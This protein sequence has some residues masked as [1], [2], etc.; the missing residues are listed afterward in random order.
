MLVIMGVSIAVQIAYGYYTFELSLYLEGLFTRQLPFWIE[1]SI[2]SLTVQVFL[3]RKYLGFGVMILY[4]I[5]AVALPALDLE[6]SLYRY[7]LTPPVLYSDMNGIGHFA[8]PLFWVNLYWLVGGMILLFL[9]NLFWVR[10]TDN[11]L[12]VRLRLARRRLARGNTIGLAAACVAFVSVGA[13][14]F[15]NANVLNPYLPTAE[16]ERRSAEYEKRYKQYDGL[17]QPRV[18]AVRVEVDIFPDT[19]RVESHGEIRLVNKTRQPIPELHVLIDP[20]VAINA[21]SLP[22]EWRTVA[23]TEVGYHIYKLESPLQ[24]GEELEVSFHFTRTNPGF[25]NNGSDTSVLRNGT[26]INSQ[27]YVPHFGYARILELVNPNERKDQ[28][29]AQRERMAPVDDREARQNTYI[30][31]EADWVDFES[32]VSTT[33]DQ[34]AIAPGYLQREW[35]E[36]GRRY[37]HYKMDA[38]ILN[39]FS[40]QSAEYTVARDRW[41]NV[42]IEILGKL[43]QDIEV[44][45]AEGEFEIEV[46]YVQP[47]GSEGDA[48][49]D[50][51][52]FA[53]HV[54]RHEDAASKLFAEHL[55]RWVALAGSER[56]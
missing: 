52:Q 49:I 32:I 19:R 45:V 13:Y 51:E 29:L 15:Y 21:I 9:A 41:Q 10:G 28:G 38:P 47:V 25:V 7:A 5:S 36:N 12:R 50:F 43:L 35:T 18:T 16:V 37:F 11:P 2:L 55:R 30:S 31:H 17:P 14:I 40:F 27:R 39:F 42:D 4:F 56:P 48:C 22:G 1:V 44:T 23:D 34:I 53:A 26:F 54:E 8:A 24:P 20:G 33:P 46:I 6:H 3:D